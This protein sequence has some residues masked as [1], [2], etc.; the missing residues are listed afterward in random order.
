[1]AIT[2]Q[3]K[4]REVRE[5]AYKKGLVVSC[6]LYYNDL[7]P[8]DEL[9]VAKLW[10]NAGEPLHFRARSLRVALNAVIRFLRNK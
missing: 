8:K 10:V 7:A 2:I 1:M 5:M 9:W 4:L 6:D 3:G